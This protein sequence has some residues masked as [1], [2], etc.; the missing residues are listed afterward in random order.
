MFWEWN[1]SGLDTFSS[2]VSTFVDNGFL[3]HWWW[4][5]SKPYFSYFQTLTFMFLGSIE[6]LVSIHNLTMIWPTWT[7]SWPLQTWQWY[8][9]S[10]SATFCF[11]LSW[12]SNLKSMQIICSW[13]QM[14]WR[15]FIFICLIYSLVSVFMFSNIL[16]L[17]VQIVGILCVIYIIKRVKG[18]AFLFHAKDLGSSI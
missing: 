18:L 12:K 2:K 14:L 7:T 5:I 9:S 6:Q 8:A 11:L 10:W 17:D 4:N 13:A 16:G 15:N 1:D 3:P